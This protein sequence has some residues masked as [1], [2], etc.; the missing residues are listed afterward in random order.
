MREQPPYERIIAERIEA[1][2]A[3]MGLTLRGM[4][5]ALNMN[6]GSYHAKTKGKFNSFRIE[7]VASIAA[8][9]RKRSGRRLAAWPWLP[10]HEVRL[11]D[12]VLELV[13]SQTGPASGPGTTG[14]ALNPAPERWAVATPV[15]WPP[16]PVE[17]LERLAERL[18]K[19]PS[20]RG[21]GR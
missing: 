3:E 19:K 13:P 2:R 8:L 18:R 1:A 6:L 11:V 12:V 9:Y 7:E 5:D 20:R 16:D 21:G 15:D 4:A 14:A 17:R 10:D